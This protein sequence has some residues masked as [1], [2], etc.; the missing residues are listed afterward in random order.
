MDEQKQKLKHYTIVKI[1]PFFGQWPEWIDLFIESCK[2]NPD[3]D[4]LIYTD[5]DAPANKADNVKL[6][7]VSFND[8]KRFV[9]DKLNINF[10]PDNAYKLCDLKPALGYIHH[11]DIA[12][13]D[14]YAFGDID[15]I[16]GNLR[17]FLT[18]QLL[19]RFDVIGT[20]ERRLSGHFCLFRNNQRN[21]EAFKKIKHWQQHLENPEHLSLDESKFSKLFVPHRKHPRWLRKLW[22]VTSRYQRRVLFKEQYSTILSPIPWHDGSSQ[23]PTVWAWKQGKLVNSQDKQQFMYL[24]FMNLKSSKWLPKSMKQSGPAW[25]QLEKLV[26]IDWRESGDKGFVVSPHGFLHPDKLQKYGLAKFSPLSLIL[27]LCQ[28]T[29]WLAVV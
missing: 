13:Y 19:Q 3:I 11:D 9:S 15:L 28:D 20:H 27:A 2:H 17:H 26:H 8:Y 22:S 7:H 14:F 12:G 6:V 25:S 23:H 5:C 18:D 21:R 16:Y 24:H 4:W 10:N 1:I 29:A